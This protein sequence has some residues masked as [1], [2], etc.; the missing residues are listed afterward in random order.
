MLGFWVILSAI[1]AFNLGW[2]R[3]ADRRLKPL[4][5]ALLWRS[6]LAIFI[7]GQLGY[8]TAFVVVPE[9]ARRAH[10][11]VPDAILGTVFL[12][13]ILV[14]PITGLITLLVTVSGWILGFIRRRRRGEPIVEQKRDILA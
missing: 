9:W 2:W 5:F 8:L 11:V 3:W 10:E 14:L 7:G 4:R 13:G 1:V 6:L 12:W